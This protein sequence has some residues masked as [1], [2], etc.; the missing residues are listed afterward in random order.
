[1]RMACAKIYRQCTETRQAPARPTVCQRRQWLGALLI[2]LSLLAPLS[3]VAQE[4]GRVVGRVTSVE[5]GAPLG[6]V[7][8]FIPGASIGTLSRQDG[9]FVILQAPPGMHE[10]R[11]ERIGYA[12]GSQQITVTAGETLEVNFRLSSEALGLDEIVVTGTAGASRRREIGSTI[13]QVNVA[14]L[15]QRPVEAVDLLQSA[16][17]GI[18]VTSTGGQLGGGSNIRLRGNTSLSMSNQPI[19]YVDGIRMQSKAFPMGRPAAAGT[20]GAA[21]NIEANPLNSIN[22]SDIERIE[23]IKGSAATTLYGTEASAGVIQIFTKRGSSGAPVWNVETQQQLSR[24]QKMG[25]ERFPYHRIDPF[26][27]N[28]YIGSY[29]ASVRGGGQQL[30]Y[31]TSGKY[32]GGVGILPQDTI[33]TWNV[34]GNFTFTPV[35]DLQFQWNTGFTRTA[36]RNTPVGGNANG[37]THNAYRGYANYFNTEDP[38]EIANAL[39]DQKY[40]QELERFTTGGTV[41]YSPV[42][43]L[44]NRLTVG[45]DYSH[46]ELRGERPFGFSRFAPGSIYN[47]TWENRLL[48]FDYVGTYGFGL[49]ESIRSNF[50]WGG[51]A[52]GEDER[53]LDGYGEGLPPGAEPTVSSAADV[54]AY[55]DR[56]KV[57]NAG[58]FFQNVFD[59]SDRYFITLGARIDGNSAFGSGFG[60]QTY[61]K[62]SLSWVISDE[63]FWQEGWGAVKVR[64]AYGQSGRAPEA[65]DAVRTWNPIG[66]S[67]RT[68]LVPLN[69]GSPD[70]GPEVTA[71]FETGFDGSWVNDR[72]SLAFTYYQQTTNDALFDVAQVASNGFTSSQRQNIGTI[73]N[74]GTET[75]INA[76]PIRGED[77]G[78]DVGLD[79][80]TNGSE[81]VDLGGIPAF[82]LGGD[83]WV[84]EGQPAPVLRGRWVSNPDEVGEPVFIENHIQGPTQP[85]LTLSPSTT[86]R[87]PAGVSLSARGEF[88][89]GH[90][91]RESNFTTG[92]VSRNAW[93]VACWDYYI[94]PYD[95]PSNNFVPPG[96]EHTL[97]L[98][99]E[100]PA[101]ERAL[102]TPSTS[103]DALTVKKGDFFRLRTVTASIPADALFPDRV[104]SAVLTLSLNNFGTWLNEDWVVGDPEMGF[105]EDFNF[106]PESLPPPTW[107]F[108]ASLRIQF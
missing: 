11:A 63:G 68:A 14:D 78:W 65:F 71:E 52:V 80:G 25:P 12:T 5:S 69:L 30:Q 15:P 34:R 37:L 73:R 102:C 20:S 2:A 62:A 58:F 6:E 54:I 67:G 82:T 36:Q 22:P 18:Q 40:K 8:V 27:S 92:G 53:R 104:S 19:I 47:D 86:I 103:V 89:G 76:S 45:Y 44:T 23:V 50:S 96:P 83:V 81:V 35:E 84:V 9:N 105:A 60:L 43:N 51:Q 79:I 59:V 75:S 17:P 72:L 56:S 99:P 29:S 91:S 16:A 10:L 31:F 93:M 57:W 42:A 90:Y 87:L 95:G 13:N 24:A 33:A 74:W 7:Q 108:N 28:G 94:N 55:E 85:T 107:S 1:M 39:F 46:Q 48:T 64:A 70:I 26:L 101:L 66:W 49:T 21:G 32:D 100:T 106:G 41:T 38:E 98:K 4:P 61:P 97:D 77:W 88:R 3:L